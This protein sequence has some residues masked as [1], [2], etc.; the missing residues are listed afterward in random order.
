MTARTRTPLLLAAVAALAFGLFLMHGLGHPAEPAPTTTT[1]TTSVAYASVPAG[2]DHEREHETR[3]PG[4]HTDLA[5]LCV[6][7]L[8][9]TWLLTAL[10]QVALIRRRPDGHPPARNRILHA[11]RAQPAPRPPDLARL[12]LLRI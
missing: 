11:L 7:V 4:T 12:S 8:F 10:V 3:T 1:T 5:A 6:A 2:H 9:G